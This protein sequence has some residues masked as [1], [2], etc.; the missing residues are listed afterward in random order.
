MS[1]PCGWDKSAGRF[2]PRRSG[3]QDMLY[4]AITVA[5]FAVSIAYV[6]FCDHV[7]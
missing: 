1:N 3:M 4:V 5:F 7:K 2:Q 6:Y